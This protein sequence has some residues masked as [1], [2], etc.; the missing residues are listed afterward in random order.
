[1]SHSLGGGQSVY[2]DLSC[3]SKQEVVKVYW[4]HR[5]KV[6]AS[7]IIHWLYVWYRFPFVHNWYL[8]DC[9]DFSKVCRACVDRGESYFTDENQISRPFVAIAFMEYISS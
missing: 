4:Y 2:H 6:E 1:M 7:D 9:Y 3:E 5:I 8:R